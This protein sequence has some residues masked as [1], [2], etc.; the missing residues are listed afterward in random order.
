MWIGTKGEDSGA[1]VEFDVADFE[2]FGEAGVFAVFVNGR[3]QVLDAVGED[4]AGYEGCGGR[5]GG[6]SDDAEG[7]LWGLLEGWVG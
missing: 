4:G 1:V 5:G 2:V 6:E 3:F 7:G